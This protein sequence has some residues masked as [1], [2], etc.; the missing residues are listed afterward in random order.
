MRKGQGRDGIMEEA[1]GF[2]TKNP[3]LNILIRT[4]ETIVFGEGN[5]A[6]YQR[7]K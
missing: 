5:E 2:S 3:L 4:Q 7:G 6:A 1:D